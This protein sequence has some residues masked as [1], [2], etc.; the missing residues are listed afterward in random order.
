MELVPRVLLSNGKR[1]IQELMA[2]RERVKL[3][4]PTCSEN[5]DSSV[6]QTMNGVDRVTCSGGNNKQRWMKVLVRV[7][8]GGYIHTQTREGASKVLN[9]T[10]HLRVY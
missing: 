2:V 1:S 7:R 3:M 4:N 10:S 5:D 9:L 6:G 8:E